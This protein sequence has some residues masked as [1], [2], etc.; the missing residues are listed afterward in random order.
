MGIMDYSLL[1]GIYHMK[2]QHHN[3]DD[4]SYD[5]SDDDDDDDLKSNISESFIATNITEDIYCGG[6]RAEI[7]EGP[8]I[9][10]FGIIDALQQYT[11]RKRFETWFRRW[12][13]RKDIRGISCINPQNYQ[14]RFI[15]YMNNIFIDEKKYK[16]KL[17]LIDKKFE[18]EQLKIYPPKQLVKNNMKTIK[19]T[20]HGSLSL[21]L[22][23][24]NDYDDNNNDNNNDNIVYPLTMPS[25]MPIKQATSLPA[26][27][28]NIVTPTSKFNN[29]SLLT[30]NN[31]NLLSTD[32]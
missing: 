13:Q 1:L 17:N 14:K 9:Y 29:N 25:S 8:G 10:F 16:Q 26:L 30:F 19:K 18:N 7:I 6:V 2:I 24:A 23:K 31:N 3:N 22:N 28:E 20:R 21:N 12:I 11:I 27:I 5:S 4:D 15:K 32:K